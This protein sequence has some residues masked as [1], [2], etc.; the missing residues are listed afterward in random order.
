VRIVGYRLQG[1]L[2]AFR[3]GEVDFVQGWSEE[4]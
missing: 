1:V 3:A 2:M 4:V